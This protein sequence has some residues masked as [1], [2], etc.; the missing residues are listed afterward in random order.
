MPKENLSPYFK[1]LNASLK[2]YKQ[3]IPRLL[4]D[5]D[6]LDR[7]LAVLQGMLQ[8]A[9][10]F[11]IVVKSLPCPALLDYIMAKM[12][13]KRL[14]VF[15][16]PFL[17]TIA[18]SA[19]AE[20][21]VLLGKPM[22]IQTAKYFYQTLNTN[23]TTFDPFRQ[24]QWLIDTPARLQQYLQLAQSLS[25]KLRINLE[26]DIG[27][28][29]GGVPDLDTLRTAL[30]LIEAHPDFLEFSGLMG[31]DPHVVKLPKIVRS[32]EKAFELACD[33]YDQCKAVIKEEFPNLWHSDLTF[34]GAGSPTLP[35]HHSARSPLNDISA[36]SCLV[37]PTTFDIPTLVAYEPA[38]YIATPILK[39][40]QGTTIPAIEPLKG[41]LNWINA[42]HQQSYFIYGGYWK[43]DY[44]YPSGLRENK[45]FGVS[46]NQSMLNAP[47]ESDLAVDDF[48]FLRPQQS[49]FVFLQFGNLLA[50]RHQEI[51]SEWKLMDEN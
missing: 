46:T 35:L 40:L 13:T 6:A 16:Q 47:L 5:L 31:Y 11:R 28:H 49:E 36:G 15:H 26:I 18:A 33:S 12:D 24:I 34:N 39:K 20:Y 7:N 10:D 4:I 50:I 51:V 27:L 2:N 14:M 19:D 44:Y 22:P 30:Q 29:R 1:R 43:A 37:K 48:V 45:L 23:N 8:A 3:A 17:S 42:A 38:C 32:Q 9:V 21:D 25:Q 41:A